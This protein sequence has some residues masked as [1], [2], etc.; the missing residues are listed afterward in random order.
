ME[1]RKLEKYKIQFKNFTGTIDS[2]QSYLNNLDQDGKEVPIITPYII[3]KKL[4]IPETDAFFILSLA[5]KEHILHKKYQVWTNDQNFLGDFEDTQSI[6]SVIT[7][8]ETGRQV[9]RD[10]YYVD[11]VFQ[12]EK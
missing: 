1:L 11:I 5:E 12:L 2:L 7:D 4:K 10:H 9:D 3:S 8:N 6:P